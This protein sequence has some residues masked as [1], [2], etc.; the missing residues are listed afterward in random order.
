M[1]YIAKTKRGAV[2]HK[3]C[4]RWM[5]RDWIGIHQST[6]PRLIHW[7]RGYGSRSNSYPFVALLR[8]RRN[9]L[10]TALTIRWRKRGELVHLCVT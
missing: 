9:A 2:M 10:I 4:K 3:Q 8:Q 7:W 1:A 5:D 6:N